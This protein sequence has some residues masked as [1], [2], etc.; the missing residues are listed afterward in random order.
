MRPEVYAPRG[1]SAMAASNV[2]KGV[3]MTVEHL[4]VPTCSDQG[5]ARWRT[6]PQTG[7]PSAGRVIGTVDNVVCVVVTNLAKA[8]APLGRLGTFVS[9][10]RRLRA[11]AP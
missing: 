1:V 5:M 4:R 8:G 3:Q 6:R 9:W 2:A 7:D 11:Q 10:L